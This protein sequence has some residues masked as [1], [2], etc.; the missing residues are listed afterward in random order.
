MFLKI[1]RQ[2]YR[3][4][5]AIGAESCF[6]AGARRLALFCGIF[7]KKINLKKTVDKYVPNIL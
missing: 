6:W 2:L 3:I 5:G 1:P 4:A 7:A